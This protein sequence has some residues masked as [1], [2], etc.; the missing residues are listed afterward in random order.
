MDE[1]R[2]PQPVTLRVRFL[3]VAVVANNAM[4]Q[5][6]TRSGSR[7]SGGPAASGSVGICHFGSRDDP[8]G[9]GLDPI[10]DRLEADGME[11]IER[12]LSAG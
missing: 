5:K 9:E 6:V 1:A 2:T 7:G 3:H 11:E 10:D 12:V 8:S 4:C